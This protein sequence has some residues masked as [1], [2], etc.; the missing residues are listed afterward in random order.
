MP[1]VLPLVVLVV[2]L[3]AVLRQLLAMALEAVVVVQYKLV[4]VQPLVVEE[5]EL[6]LLLVEL[7]QM[8]VVPF[9]AAL[10]GEGVVV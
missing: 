5:E 6:M 9:M 2:D 10:E 3:E 7:E 8:V 4:V 1:M